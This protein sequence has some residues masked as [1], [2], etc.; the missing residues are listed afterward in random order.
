M[1]HASDKP[2]VASSIKGKGGRRKCLENEESRQA[3]LKDM[4]TMTLDYDN[5]DNDYDE[6]DDYYYSSSYTAVQ[7]LRRRVVSL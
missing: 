3:S 7:R 6:D 4:W 2:R 5:G 1:F